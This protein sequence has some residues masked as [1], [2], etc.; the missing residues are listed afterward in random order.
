MSAGTR[1]SVHLRSWLCDCLKLTTTVLSHEKIPLTRLRC[2]ALQM[3]VDI[4]CNHFPYSALVIHFGS[5]LFH[6]CLIKLQSKM[7]ISADVYA[8]RGQFSM[9]HLLCKKNYSSSWM[10]SHNCDSSTSKFCSFFIMTTPLA[11]VCSFIYSRR[12]N[13]VTKIKITFYWNL[14][15]VEL[16]KV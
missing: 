5:S 3:S 15:V 2:H 14:V 10:R 11:I 16:Y 6:C 9:T 7:N 12:W 4:D 1:S 13:S 8:W